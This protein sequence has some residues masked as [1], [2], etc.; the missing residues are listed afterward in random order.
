MARRTR[1][2]HMISAAGHTK[3]QQTENEGPLQ[4][5]TQANTSIQGV[6]TSQGAAKT[7]RQDIILRS[8]ACILISGN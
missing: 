4:G 7:A 2:S 5:S 3:G 1:Q 6:A 8:K